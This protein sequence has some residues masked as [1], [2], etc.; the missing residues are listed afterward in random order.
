MNDGGVFNREVPVFFWNFD[1]CVVTKMEVLSPLL[2]IAPWDT[3]ISVFPCRLFI[4]AAPWYGDWF[5]W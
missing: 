1:V 2:G 4:Y 3:V 5:C